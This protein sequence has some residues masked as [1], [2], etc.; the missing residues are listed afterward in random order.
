MNN[1]NNK[2]TNTEHIAIYEYL[3]M[4]VEYIY[5]VQ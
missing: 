2:L 1:N 4:Y 3:C 5:S